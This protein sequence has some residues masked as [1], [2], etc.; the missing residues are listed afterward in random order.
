MANPTLPYSLAYQYHICELCSCHTQV[1]FR[2]EIRG[3]DYRL[4]SQCREDNI[5]QIR[6]AMAEDMAGADASEA[7]QEEK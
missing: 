3:S 6:D 5:W 4:C 7:D 1:L 2:E